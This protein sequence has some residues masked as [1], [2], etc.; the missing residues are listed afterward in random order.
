MANGRIALAASHAVGNGVMQRS[1]DQGR[2]IGG[3]PREDARKLGARMVIRYQL[4]RN[5]AAYDCKRSCAQV[6]PVALQIR[7]AVT[8]RSQ[9]RWRSAMQ[10]RSEEAEDDLI[11]AFDQLMREQRKLEEMLIHALDQQTRD[12]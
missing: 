3:K 2:I 12:T 10:D 1:L 8:L 7:M 11:L 6:R 4:D 9:R 5:K